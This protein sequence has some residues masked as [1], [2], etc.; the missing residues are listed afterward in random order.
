MHALNFQVEVHPHFPQSDLIEYCLKNAIHVQ[1][2]SSL[3]T[4]L[5]LQKNPLLNDEVVTKVAGEVG[6]TPAQVLLR[7]ALQKGLSIIPKSVNPD[8]I[9]QNIELDFEISSKQMGLLD[10][11]EKVKKYAWNPD[12]VL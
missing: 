11:I 12:R 8:H 10:S 3:G 2:Y 6:K 4:T 7:W 1:A 9:A 5:P